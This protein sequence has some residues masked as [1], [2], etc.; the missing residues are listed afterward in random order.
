MGCLFASLGCPHPGREARGRTGQ[1]VRD[2]P[3]GPSR[4]PLSRRSG[5]EAVCVDG[6]G[7]ARGREEGEEG[8]GLNSS[9]PVSGAASF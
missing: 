2:T 5:L 8:V 9:L 3:L 4:R 1:S 6:F 7:S